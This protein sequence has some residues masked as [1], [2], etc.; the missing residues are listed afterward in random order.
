MHSGEDEVVY[1][2]EGVN[3]DR[4][5]A[6]LDSINSKFKKKITYLTLVQGGETINGQISADVKVRLRVPYSFLFEAYL[7]GYSDCFS[8]FNPIG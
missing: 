1:W 6:L 2:Q 5:L 3:N 8:M 4:E 7:G